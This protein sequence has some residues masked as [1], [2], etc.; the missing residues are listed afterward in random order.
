MGQ[1]VVRIGADGRNEANDT[2]SPGYFWLKLYPEPESI[3]KDI[4]NSVSV[5]VNQLA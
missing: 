5:S 3:L 1:L 4:Q 2:P